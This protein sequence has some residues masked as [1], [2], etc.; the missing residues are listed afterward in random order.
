[1]A[2]MGYAWQIWRGAAD[3]QLVPRIGGANPGQSGLIACDPEARCAIV[4]LTN[5][6][7]G[8][9]AL[10]AMLDGL[11]PGAVADDEPAPDDLDRYAGRYAS[12]LMEV[13]IDVGAA[14]DRLE[15]HLTR[16]DDAR[17]G[18]VRLAS[19]MV[20]M[21]SGPDVAAQVHVLTP[22][23]RTTFSS[24]LGPAAFID[25]GDDGRPNLVRWRMRALRRVSP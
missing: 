12:H 23:D 2:G 22:V 18:S 15:L 10:N 1:M 19:V 6:D 17:W 21:P 9:N 16:V 11:G 14:G 3:G 4:A 20:G 24:S 25:L 13:A 5:S 7:Q 8:V